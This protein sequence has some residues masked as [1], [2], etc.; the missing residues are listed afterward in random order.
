VEY[1]IKLDERQAVDEQA[2]EMIALGVHERT[3]EGCK[4]PL[5]KMDCNRPVVARLSP[6][7]DTT[8]IG[9]LRVV[10]K[11]ML[12]NGSWIEFLYF[13]PPKRPN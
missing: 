7:G 4:P 12:V 11:R 3:E 6:S 2:A 1:V 13:L 10:R 8:D 9:S 5:S